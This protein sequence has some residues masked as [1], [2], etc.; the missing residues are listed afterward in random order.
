MLNTEPLF[1]PRDEPLAVLSVVVSG[2]GLQYQAMHSLGASEADQCSNVKYLLYYFG[3]H[4]YCTENDLRILE[5][6]LQLPEPTPY[7]TSP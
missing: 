7:E 6:R 3:P 2:R 4:R 5:D 1:S